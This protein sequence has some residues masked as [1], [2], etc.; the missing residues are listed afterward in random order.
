MQSM[1]SEW[2]RLRRWPA[3][4]AAIAGLAVTFIASLAAPIGAAQPAANAPLVAPS[5]MAAQQVVD[6]QGEGEWR[7]YNGPDLYQVEPDVARL[8]VKFAPGWSADS[9]T[10][11]LARHADVDLAAMADRPMSDRVSE[12]G[13]I[14]VTL[15]AGLDP[16]AVTNARRV[17]ESDPRVEFAQPV[18]WRTGEKLGLTNRML[19]SFAKGTKR[20]QLDQLARVHGLR[21]VER[22]EYVEEGYLIEIARG[23]QRTALG[24]SSDMME[25]GFFEWSLPEFVVERVER[26][27]PADPNYTSQWHLN[28]TGQ[29]GAKVDADVDAPEAWDTQKG[30]ASIIVA[31]IDGGIEYTHED[32]TANAVAGYDFLSNDATPLPVGTGDNHGTAC[33][34]VAVAKQDNAKGVSG[35]APNCKLMPIRLVGTGMTTTMEANSISFAKNN[36]AAIMSNSWGPP[37]G[38]GANYP[39][40][41]NVKSAID[42]ARNNGRGGLGCLIFWASGNGNESVEL[43]GYASYANVIAVGASTDQDKRA[44]YSDYGPSLD[45]CAP[46]NGGST[47]GIWTVD[48]TGSAGYST[49]N[50]ANNFG[51]TSSACPLAAGVGAL[52]LSQTPT[53]TWTQAY[54]VLTSTADKIDTAGGAY[55]GGFSVYYGYGKVNAAAAVAAAGGTTPPSGSTTIIATD[56]PKSI[57]DNNTT[58][59]TSNLTVSGL[60]NSLTEVDISVNITH[61]YKGDLKVTLV[62]PDG[63]Q[64]L[65][66]NQTGGSAD[67]IVTTFDT[68]TIPAQSLAGLVGKAPNGTWQLKVQDLASTDVGTLNGWSLI[69]KTGTTTTPPTTTNKVATDVP[70]AIPDNNTTGVTSTLAVSGLTGTLQDVNITVAITHTYKGDLRVTLIHP[71]GT[72]VILHNQTGGSA[73]NINTTYDTLTAP[74]QA[75]SAFNGKSANGTWQL[76]IQDLAAADTGTLTAWTLQLVHQ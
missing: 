24:I 32:L 69:V 25:S 15:R 6:P 33:A 44:Y 51:G 31:V 65:L 9:I 45:I 56:V 49:T 47:T 60:S 8:S 63:T 76:K 48:R 29:G 17:L 75:L 50:Y 30:S 13:W 72:Q 43:D 26:Y 37:D 10:D 64:I 74:A 70:K 21:V 14:E 66:H 55:S 73:D 34:G 53:L 3:R 27:T 39:L 12:L 35:I 18:V 22:L 62:H 16:A 5:A 52:V 68:L 19:V 58:G 1:Q 2:G 28:S 57:P 54:S 42:D 71:D 23:S 40:P 46:S 41:A 36:G 61:T 67:N 20:S 38:T 11:T 4:R 7:Y 59:V